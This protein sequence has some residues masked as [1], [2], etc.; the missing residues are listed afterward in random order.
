MHNYETRFIVEFYQV[1]NSVKVTAIDP[2]TFI[3]ATIIGPTNAPRDQLSQLAV[4]K[5]L[6]I[7][8]K[9]SL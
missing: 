4:K 3:E 7:L 6:Y 8:N 2:E 9:E 5:L 1:G